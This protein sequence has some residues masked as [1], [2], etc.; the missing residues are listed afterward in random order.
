MNK[1][2]MKK[3]ALLGLAAGA[4]MSTLSAPEAFADENVIDLQYVIAKP[5]CKAHGGCGGLTASRDM[6]ASME[7]NDEEDDEEEDDGDEDKKGHEQ[8]DVSK[9]SK[10]KV[11]A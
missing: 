3:L 5:K 6:N 2:E 7:D 10:P 9:P 11:L 4:I 1:E 8:R